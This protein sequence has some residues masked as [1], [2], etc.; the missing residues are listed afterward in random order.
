MGD[1]ITVSRQLGS[2]GSTI[3]TEVAMRLSWS[4]LD[5]EI[6][7]RAAEIAGFPDQTM[8]DKLEDHEQRQRVLQRI[9][10]SLPSVSAPP[11]TP[12]ATVREYGQVTYLPPNRV[13]SG[14]SNAP[15]P[16]VDIAERYAMTSELGL[17]AQA[18]KGYRVLIEQAIR[19][20]A[21]KGEAVIVGRGGQATLRDMP[22]IL[23]VLII[24]PE[25]DRIRRLAQR[26]ELNETDA[27]RM[28]RESDKQRSLY[29][30]HYSHA[31]WLDASLYDLTID[32]GKLPV[33]CAV[34]II[35]EAARWP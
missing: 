35:C 25:A 8:L 17:R 30:K 27:Q 14:G 3:A 19:E 1:V 26:M 7:H 16:H 15:N 34:D 6:L 18:A 2:N 5:R 22:G 31:N 10:D 32:T 4:Y 28:V 20:Q 29:L 24:A 23:H 33:E 11:E 12:S 13:S 9:R 21:E